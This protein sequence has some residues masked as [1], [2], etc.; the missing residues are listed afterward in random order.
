MNHDNG[1]QDHHRKKCAKSCLGEPGQG[2]PR[3][4]RDYQDSNHHHPQ[5]LVTNN[6]HSTTHLL[7]IEQ[8][9]NASLGIPLGDRQQ[10]DRE[11]LQRLARLR[12]L[13]SL[14]LP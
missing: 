11:L 5:S 6:R 7:L 1:G 12:V 14:G 3:H 10:H 8:S 9:A 13:F 4:D 2:S